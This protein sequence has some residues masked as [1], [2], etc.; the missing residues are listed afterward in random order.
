MTSLH[1]VTQIIL[2]QEMNS[3]GC[4]LHHADRDTHPLVSSDSNTGKIYMGHGT[5]CV[6]R[7]LRAPLNHVCMQFGTMKLISILSDILSRT[8]STS[9]TW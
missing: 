5:L 1:Q 4:P 8:K 6:L 7:K 3:G 9:I 2:L